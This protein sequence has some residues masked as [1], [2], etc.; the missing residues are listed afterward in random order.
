M[1]APTP[2][3]IAMPWVE[4]TTSAIPALPAS[5]YLVLARFE[6]NDPNALKAAIWPDDRLVGGADFIS[7][8]PVGTT[9]VDDFPSTV[10]SLTYMDQLVPVNPAYSV[11]KSKTT[12][13]LRLGDTGEY[14]LIMTAEPATIPTADT[15]G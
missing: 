5:Y 6:A 1:L 12:V 7:P 13:S 11:I 15:E 3:T 4:T 9:H 8:D 2:T 14:E 10:T